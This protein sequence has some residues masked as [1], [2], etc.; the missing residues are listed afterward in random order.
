MKRKINEIYPKDH[1]PK[2]F[3]VGLKKLKED[4]NSQ[5]KNLIDDKKVN[6]LTKKILKFSKYQK[7]IEIEKLSNETGCKINFLTR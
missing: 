3:D 1:Q 7:E 2:L 6:F 5:I 4:N